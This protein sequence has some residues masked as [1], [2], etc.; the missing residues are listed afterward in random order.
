MII[1]R[2]YII[3]SLYADILKAL[4]FFHKI[5][6][7]WRCMI[8]LLNKIDKIEISCNVELKGKLTS[9]YITVSCN[10]NLTKVD[11]AFFTTI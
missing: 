4:Q 3:Y 7:V 6:I 11:Y 1:K 9:I 5:K 10:V 8:K 2:L